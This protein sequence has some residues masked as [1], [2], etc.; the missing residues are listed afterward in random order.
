[1]ENHYNRRTALKSMAGGA[2]VLASAVLLPE[3]LKAA[4]QKAFRL[5]GN[6]NHSVC[7]WCYKDIPLED[8]CKAAKGIGLSSIELLG[9]D[10]W[11]MLK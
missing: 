9:P 3:P 11:P 2:A 5:K 1:M 10:D 8:L 4:G 7:K 6:I